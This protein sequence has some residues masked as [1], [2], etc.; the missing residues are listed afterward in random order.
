M[1]SIRTARALATLAAV[2]LAF[3]ALS[4]VAHADAAVGGNSYIGADN[5]NLGNSSITQQ[6][7][8]GPGATNLSQTANAIGFGNVIDQ[9]QPSFTF[10]FGR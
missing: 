7:A 5:D 8:Q 2:P 9:S 1:A 10:V 4:G 6:N 3:A